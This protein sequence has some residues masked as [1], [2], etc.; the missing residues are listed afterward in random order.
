MGYEQGLLKHFG[1]KFTPEWISK[2]EIYGPFYQKL[3]KLPLVVR[4]NEQGGLDGFFFFAGGGASDIVDA[5]LKVMGRFRAVKFVT[6]VPLGPA[7]FSASVVP[8]LDDSGSVLAVATLSVT[9]FLLMVKL[10]MIIVVPFRFVTLD[11]AVVVVI[12]VV[13]LATFK[14]KFIIFIY[15]FI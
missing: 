1:V 12:T 10:G 3:E 7:V 6:D 11:V 4:K 9:D 8:L 14:S 5:S 13:L 15:I 2:I